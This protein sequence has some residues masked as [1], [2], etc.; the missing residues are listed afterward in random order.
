MIQLLS[1]DDGS[2]LFLGDDGYYHSQTSDSV[3]EIYDGKPLKMNSEIKYANESINSDEYIL[4]SPLVD[5]VGEENLIF[6][7]TPQSESFDENDNVYS[8]FFNDWKKM[9]KSVSN[10]ESIDLD[11]ESVKEDIM[12]FAQLESKRQ[13]HSDPTETKAYFKEYLQKIKNIYNSENDFEDNI[14]STFS[15]V[16]NKCTHVLEKITND[17]SSVLL[18]SYFSYD[19]EFI[20]GLLIPA[21]VGYSRRNRSSFVEV[22]PNPRNTSVFIVNAYAEDGNSLSI[23]NIEEKF[24]YEIKYNIEKIP[25]L[26]KDKDKEKENNSAGYVGLIELCI[27]TFVVTL[28]VGIVLAIQIMQ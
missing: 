16:N 3:F 19:S 22:K 15:I 6:D 12:Y 26:N 20:S 23:N 13:E 24:A 1:P 17:F 14:K 21:I 10:I 8:R 27:L 4:D 11:T 5:T 25:N 2:E 28:V 18:C 7:E 9:L